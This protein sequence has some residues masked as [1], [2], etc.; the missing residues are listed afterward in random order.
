MS[1]CTLV[2]YERSW[3]GGPWGDYWIRA[4]SKDKE[5]NKELV[6]DVVENHKHGRKGGLRKSLIYNFEIKSSLVQNQ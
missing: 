6:T 2:N 5:L 4:E 1:I 3:M